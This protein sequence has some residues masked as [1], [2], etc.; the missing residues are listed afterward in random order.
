ML[1]KTVLELDVSET[2]AKD[3]VGKEGNCKILRFYFASEYNFNS[4]F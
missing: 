2:T 3:W 1:I 4:I